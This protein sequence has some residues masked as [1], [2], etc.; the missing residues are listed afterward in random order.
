MSDVTATGGAN[1]HSAPLELKP[2]QRPGG[3]ARPVSAEPVPI[4]RKPPWLTVKWQQG[5][6]YRDLKGLMR[7]AGRCKQNGYQIEWGVGR[8][9]PVPAD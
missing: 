5:E 9:G 1:G 7:G 4:E 3:P 2:Y 6:N 8:H